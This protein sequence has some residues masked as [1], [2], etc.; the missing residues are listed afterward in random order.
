MR[1]TA[2]ILKDVKEAA[3]VPGSAADRIIAIRQ[4]E[5]TLGVRDALVDIAQE[6]RGVYRRARATDE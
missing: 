4:L 2:E 3:N 5:A 1:T 6:I